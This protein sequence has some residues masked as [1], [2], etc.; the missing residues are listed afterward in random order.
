MQHAG[1]VSS[2]QLN[3]NKKGKKRD[4]KS[5]KPPSKAK[6]KSTSVLSA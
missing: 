5:F 6:D 3:Q 1:G 4:L 2:L